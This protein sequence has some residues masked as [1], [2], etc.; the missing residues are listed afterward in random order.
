MGADVLANIFQ[1]YFS[2][3]GER[4][5]GLGVPIVVNAV[6]EHGGALQLQSSIGQGTSFAIYWPLVD[7][8]P[9]DD[10]SLG[11][12][13]LLLYAADP[14]RAGQIAAALEAQGALVVP[15]DTWAE[16]VALA[17]DADDWDALV[18]D[19]QAGGDL[20]L[21][22]RGLPRIAHLALAQGALADQAETLLPVCR[23]DLDAD[24][25]SAAL[26]DRLAV[27]LPDRP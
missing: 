6:Q 22:R 17:A 8:T 9:T 19:I 20:D 12:R 2:T 11:N 23:A 13:S 21:V 10:D 16:A 27:V 3:K 25:F 5:T 18:L 1:P 26:A 4:G 14:A 24:G 15:C 7:D